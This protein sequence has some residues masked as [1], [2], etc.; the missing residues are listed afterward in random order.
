MK[1]VGFTVLRGAEP[2]SFEFEVVD[3]VRNFPSGVTGPTRAAILIR[4]HGQYMEHVGGVQGMSGSPC[5]IPDDTGQLRLIGAYAFGFPLEKEGPPL[6]GVQP[7]E[8]MLD[9]HTGPASGLAEDVPAAQSTVDTARLGYWQRWLPDP[10]RYEQVG[11]IPSAPPRRESSRQAQGLAGYM[12][13]LSIPLAAGAASDYTM[14]LLREGLP[15]DT[16]LVPMAGPTGG[17][18]DDA[19]TD[20]GPAGVV[21]IPFVTG[22][23]DLA[24]IGTA[25]YCTTDDATGEKLVYAFGHLMEGFG[26][27]ELPMASGRIHTVIAHLAS[28]F[29]LG[30][31]GKLTGTL[32]ADE[33]T[34]VVG[35][36]GKVPHMPTLTVTVTHPY[37][38]KPQT[39]HYKLAHHSAFTDYFTALM[40][41]QSI[42]AYT[43]LPESHTIEHHVELEFDQAGTFVASNTTSNYSLWGIIG[44]TA[45]PIFALMNSSFGKQKLVSARVEVVVRDEAIEAMIESARLV[46]AVVKPGQSLRA[47]LQ[48]RPWRKEPVTKELTF[49][50]PDDMPDGKYTLVI[51]DGDTYM[52]LDQGDNP[53]RYRPESA[54]Q[55]LAA[56]NRI[57]AIRSDMLYMYLQLPEAG[58][59]IKDH[60]LPNVPSYMAAVLA[61]TQ[62]ESIVPV[63]Q[64]IVRQVPMPYVFYNSV[65]LPFTV[66]RRADQ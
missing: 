37:R 14:Q 62:R 23:L 27:V 44:D 17:D 47:R 26:P 32:I 64:S 61:G 34:G 65:E 33:T 31:V 30:S 22:D 6:V 29:K 8:Q 49:D 57:G 50:V 10:C 59:A 38:T 53:N 11:L 1:G 13:P 4:V 15:R 9:I 12:K 41:V 55:Q 21:A 52:R 5:Y 66:D 36:S 35:R 48:I 63:R 39:Y 28:S 58:V 40:T 56:F 51:A 54:R 3:V 60:E 18:A 46:H 25:T 16:N 19:P 42:F 2:E 20:I 43:S 45:A 7:I 24:G